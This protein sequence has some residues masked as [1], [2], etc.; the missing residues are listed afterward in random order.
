MSDTLDFVSLVPWTM[1]MQWGNL[2]I[3]FLLMKKFLFKPIKAVLAKREEEI[4]K[5]YSSAETAETEAKAMKEEYEARLSSAKEEAGEIVRT[6][7][8][9]AQQRGDEIVGEAQRQAAFL[10][11]KA[12]ADI[13]QE[14]KKAINEVKNDIS[15]IAVD[16]ASKV[17][18]REIS[19][20][21]HE[22]LIE[23]FISNVG[24]AS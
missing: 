21:D 13:A 9:K 8:Q 4:G 17:V 19:A 11:E 22:A 18:E 7:T 20:K 6:A 16:I 1:V 14:K 10:K 2:L 15:G 23:E 12:Q 3:I 24:D 5:M